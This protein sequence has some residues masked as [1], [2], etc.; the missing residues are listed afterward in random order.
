[1]ACGK[2]KWF[3]N[4]KGFGFIVADGREEDIFA[5]FSTIVMDGYKTLKAGQDVTFELQAGPKGLHA[6]N[7]EPNGDLLQ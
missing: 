1:M 7:I 2:V 6:T 3:N 5:H 4:A